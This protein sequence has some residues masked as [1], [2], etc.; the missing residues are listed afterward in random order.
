MKNKKL[1]LP[2]GFASIFYSFKMAKRAGGLLKFL[3]ALKSDN[4]CKSCGLGMGG[5]AG[6]MR[7]ELKRYPEVCK[8]SLQAQ[9]SD[10]QNGIAWDFFERHSILELQ[11]WSARDLELSG[12]LHQPL[13]CLPGETHYR[14]ISWSEALQIITDKLKKISPE[15]TFFY[16]SGR[17]S[18][19][20]GFLL[21]LFAR[22]YGTNNVNNCSYYCHQ[23][24]GVALS[25][26]LGT[27]TAT[28]RL[29]DLERAD[30]IF[31]IGANPASNHP[32][33]ITTLMKT[34]RRG[35]KVIIVN[36][37]RESGLERFSVPSDWRSLLF[38]S[39][40][41]STYVMPH[42]GGDIALF[43][44]IAKAIFDIEKSKPEI[45]AR[46][47]I[48]NSSEGFKEWSIQ[49]QAISWDKIE[50]SSGISQ[51][52]I[53]DL[54][55]QY[56]QAKNVIFAWG[57]GLT[58]HTHGVNNILSMI[59]LGFLRGMVG[60]PHAGFLPLRGHSNVQ[61]IGSVGV[62]PELKK[63]FF[64]NLSK[65]YPIPMP[66]EKGLD[67]MASMERAADSKIDFAF[68][69]GGNLFGSNP[70]SIFAKM[71]FSKIDIVV[72]LNTTLNLGHFEGLG[73]TTLILPV[74][75]RDEEPKATTQE[76]MFSF[77]RLSNGGKA[78]H[79]GPRSESAIL[80]DIGA[81]VLSNKM[82]PWKSFYETSEIRKMI[83]KVVPGYEKLTSIDETK[84]EFEITGRIFHR[85]I[86]N[87]TSGKA[88]FIPVPINK[89]FRSGK[90][91]TLMTM[92]SEGQFNSIVF[93]LYDRYRGVD[94]RDIVF[95]NE[96]DMRTLGLQ[97]RQSVTIK[98]ASGK[99]EN[100]KVESFAIKRGNIMMYYPEANVLIP[101][102]VDPESRT[103]GFK[104]VAAE[105]L[106]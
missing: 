37:A 12:R 45:I 50:E 79:Q 38:G 51:K 23:A 27:S 106:I 47:F 104:S 26:T 58:H 63:T 16:S 78:R 95:M 39:K 48:D 94:S 20:A 43:T 85:P 4:A 72:Y 41:A 46:D 87:T 73:K 14:A 6:G 31:V 67:T 33:F 19:E 91:F 29:S 8:K 34:R 60:R 74:L 10:M 24:S 92:R 76:S 69:L 54:A 30:L 35:G 81:M 36:P 75:A 62:T 13:I 49:V 84:N 89:S 56:S 61:G 64:E 66:K 97:Q 15:K 2:G 101:R 17:S 93:D 3:R 83:G 22:A 52:E 28:V 25:K 77:V 7:D 82:I 96:E 103:P 80:A 40:I 90:T 5:Q 11:K 102:D 99:L 88:Q 105:I 55:R 42:V 18:N 21:Q 57:M 100:Q 70:D 65:I 1:P 59:N 32:R 44:G 9:A 68:N 98:T 53:E 86:F 71:A